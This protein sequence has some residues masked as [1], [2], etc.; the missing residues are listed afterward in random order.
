LK[1]QIHKEGLLMYNILT[2]N[3]ISAS[4]LANFD[5]EKYVCGDDLEEPIAAIVRSAS[6][7]D[8]ELPESLIAIARAGAGVNNIPID[9]CTKKGIVVFNTPGANANAVKELAVCGLLLASRRI[10]PAIDW[11][12]TLKGGGDD[13]PKQVEK[14]KSNFVG[15]EIAGKTLG[16]VGM[17]AIGKLV[18][19]AAI[20]LGMSVVAYDICED[21]EAKAIITKGEVT[22]DVSDVF[23]KSDYISLHCP[24]VS[25]TKNM[26]NSESLAKCRDGVRILNFARGDLVNTSDILAGIKSGKVAA[27]VTDFPDDEM[28]GVDGVIAI[29][30]LGASTPESEENCAVMAVNQLADFIENGNIKNSVNFPNV[31]LERSDKYRVC[32]MASKDIGVKIADILGNVTASAYDFNKNFYGIFDVAEFDTDVDSSVLNKIADLEGVFGIR[33]I[34]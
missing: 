19:D 26:I 33:V 20:K 12:K 21:E 1:K 22:C 13:V 10:V 9:D 32:V 2:L 31:S 4:G 34:C 8:V 5:A 29:P 16:I 28:L 11:A 18:A 3:K 17:G 25:A 14:G 7:H 24:S 30:H 27:Y 23:E 15:P 6:L